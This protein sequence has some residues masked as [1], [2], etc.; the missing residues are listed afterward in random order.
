MRPY[1]PMRDPDIRAALRSQ[2]A[3]ESEPG[4]VVID[5]LALCDGVARIDVAAVGVLVCGYEIKSEGDTLR[6]LDGQMAAYNRALSRVTLVADSCHLATA[7][8]GLP[9][10]WGLMEAYWVDSAVCLRSLRQAE[11]N[12]SLDPTAV[13]QFLWRAEAL[14]MLEDAGHA[15]GVRSKRICELLARL[16]TVVATD[17]LARLVAEQ[18]RMRGD[19]R[20]VSRPSPGGDQSRRVAKSLHSPSHLCLGRIDL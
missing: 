3:E 9:E 18:I 11:D 10:W 1:K 13:A 5:E 7:A 16:S 4:T 14:K 17:E 6:R 19:W 15:K 12:P 8:A 20:A 2:L